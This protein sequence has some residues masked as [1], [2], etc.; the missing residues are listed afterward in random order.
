M[1]RWM[2]VVFILV[3]VFG[4]TA[5][6]QKNTYK[7]EIADNRRIENEL[8]ASYEAG[9]KVTIQLGTI[10]EHYYRLYVNGVE[11]KMDRDASDMMYTYYTFVMP[12]EH[13]TV[14]IEDCYVD[15]PDA[16]VQNQETTSDTDACVVKTYEVTD[17]EDAT[18]TDELV[19]FVT[20][21]EMSDGTWKTE[22]YTYKYRLEKTGRVHNAA[23]DTT[24]VFLSNIEN[25]TFEQMWKAAGLSSNRNDY[26]DADVARFVGMK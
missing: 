9:E 7:V 8:K 26:F 18:E 20:H 5:C 1:K 17:S 22:N 10:T 24:F 16:P 11:Q 6:K 12:S 25:I 21:Y 13:V 3:F 19:I 4:M 15:I 23:S 14:K 2:K